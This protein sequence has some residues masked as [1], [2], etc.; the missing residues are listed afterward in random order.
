MY[1][2]LRDATMRIFA[3]V[4]L[5]VNVVHLFAGAGDLAMSKIALAA[6]VLNPVPRI[7]ASL[8][9]GSE[10]RARKA[11]FEPVPILNTSQSLISV[12]TA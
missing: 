1:T 7:R 12:S 11:C 8:G 10:G 5:C 9:A 3:P 6:L 4:R 2:G